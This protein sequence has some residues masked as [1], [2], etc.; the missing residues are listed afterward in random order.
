MN[1]K[2]RFYLFFYMYEFCLYIFVCTMF[3]PDEKRVLDPLKLELKTP[4]NSHV[5]AGNF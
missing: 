5:G 2:E 3:V 4:V 1:S